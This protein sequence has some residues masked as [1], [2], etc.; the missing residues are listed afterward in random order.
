MNVVIDQATEDRIKRAIAKR[1]REHGKSF[2]KS[3]WGRMAFLAQ[4]EREGE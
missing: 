1:R 4:L 3:A 2:G